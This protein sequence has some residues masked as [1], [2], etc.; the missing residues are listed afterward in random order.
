MRL[1]HAVVMS[2]LPDGGRVGAATLT[3]EMR[4][5]APCSAIAGTSYRPGV[6]LTQPQPLHLG[7]LLPEETKL[8]QAVAVAIGGFPRLPAARRA[9][10]RGSFLA[11]AAP[12]ARRPL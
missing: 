1:R 8:W 6:A 3:R 11:Q 10:R 12:Q 4:G 5:A 7:G 2:T 9:R